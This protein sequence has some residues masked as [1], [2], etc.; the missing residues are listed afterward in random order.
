MIGV[1]ALEQTL[2]QIGELLGYETTVDAH[3]R[4]GQRRH[5]VVV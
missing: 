1:D 3:E 4:V 5:L 2:V